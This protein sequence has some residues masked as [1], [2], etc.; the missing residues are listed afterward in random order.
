MGSEST[1]EL[2]PS[3]LDA[4]VP[5]VRLTGS[6]VSGKPDPTH[7]IRSGRQDPKNRMPYFC[8]LNRKTKSEV[9][10]KP[11]PEDIN[12]I[13]PYFWSVSYVSVQMSCVLVYYRLH[14][15]VLRSNVFASQYLRSNAFRPIVIAAII[16]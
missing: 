15:N 7:G 5:E 12:D 4:K 2:A 9:T 14:S 1:K 10:E 11:G 13:H 6:E 3:G 16:I 8:S